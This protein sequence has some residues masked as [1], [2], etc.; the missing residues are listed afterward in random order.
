MNT[1]PLS[2]PTLTLPRLFA[3]GFFG[4]PLALV[5]L[6]IYVH[7]PSFYFHHFGLSLTLIGAILL[8]AR[9]LDAFLDPAIGCWLDRMKMRR[10][11]ARLIVLALPLLVI[12]FTGL[13]HPLAVAA[14]ASVAWLAACLLV[15]YA[16]YSIATIA[17]QSWGAALSQQR[18]ERTRV[19]A[20]REACGLVGVM[21][22]AILPQLA[23]M[24][25]LT[26]LFILSLVVGAFLLLK[27][28]PA[29][30]VIDGVQD[31]PHPARPEKPDWRLPFSQ[32]AFR[33][34][35][36][37]FALN[38][39]AAAI[40]ATLFLFFVDDKLGL[41]K[42]SGVFLLLYF[43]SAA[44]ALPLWTR[45]ATRTG[46]ARTWMMSMLL[47]MCAFAW[48]ALLPPGAISGFAVICVVSGAALGA[49]LA[50]PPA[51][52]AGVIGLAG[53]S[54]SK[55]GAYFGIWSW[56]TKMN[57][58][59]A[60]GLTLPLLDLLGYVPGSGETQGIWSLTIAYAGLPCLLKLA[61]LLLLWRSP[62]NRI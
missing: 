46:E 2:R 18:G 15:V 58:A 41:G 23:G 47:A 45:L 53:H 6:P 40:P 24:P 54:D 8:G 34:L 28:A 49:D 14:Q 31:S 10:K 13:F 35:A 51:L 7:V 33:W 29:P 55:E 43:L 20:M 57:L 48:A 17:H 38:G 3:Y 9:V 61:A 36:G 37:V 39:I 44:L 1:L 27:K 32:P 16:G 30:S 21:A 62:L 42:F 5:A 19:T 50:L 11:H 12:G 60:A 26:I 59:L 56:I 25:A 22:A 52:L 4:L